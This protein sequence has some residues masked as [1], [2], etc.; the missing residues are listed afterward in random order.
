MRARIALSALQMRRK[1]LRLSALVEA[2]EER[3]GKVALLSRTALR[4]HGSRPM[5]LKDPVNYRCP[6]DRLFKPKQ[7]TSAR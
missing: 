3:E 6:V 1:R 5:T 2:D 7:T 4:R